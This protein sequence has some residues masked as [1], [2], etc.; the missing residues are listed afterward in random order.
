MISAGAASSGQIGIFAVLCLIA[1]LA[2][3]G[4]FYT[5]MIALQH[6]FTEMNPLNRWLFKKI[7]QQWTA[8]IEIV[9]ALFLAGAISNYSLSAG[10]VFVGGLCAIEIAMCIRSYFLLKKSNISL[11]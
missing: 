6:G 2:T 4:D 8:F 9:F 10:Y 1:V 3:L 5:T 7:G 11:K